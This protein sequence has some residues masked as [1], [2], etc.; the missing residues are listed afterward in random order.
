MDRRRLFIRQQIIYKC[1]NTKSIL[2]M[3]NRLP[4]FPLLSSIHPPILHFEVIESLSLQVQ[5]P[6]DRN[7]CAD[8]RE[9]HY[10][11]LDCFKSS[12]I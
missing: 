2:R 1:I 4:I 6:Q 3:S 8:Q 5:F 7:D 11:H 12:F 9:Q 10:V